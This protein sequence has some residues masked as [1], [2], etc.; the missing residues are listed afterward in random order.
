[1][2][3]KLSIVP[4]FALVVISHIIRSEY[5]CVLQSTLRQLPYATS[6]F[7]QFL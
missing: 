7:G 6:K 3:A 1:M 5:F 4:L 2:I